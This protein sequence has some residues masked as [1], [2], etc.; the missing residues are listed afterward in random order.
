MDAIIAEWIRFNDYRLVLIS[1]LRYLT[2]DTL[3]MLIKGKV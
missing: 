3:I 1:H 2:G